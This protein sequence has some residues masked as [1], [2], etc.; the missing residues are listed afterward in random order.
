MVELLFL[1]SVYSP[2]PDCH[3][4]HYNAETLEIDW[5]GMLRQAGVPVVVVLLVGA[6][7]IYRRQRRD[8]DLA[9]LPTYYLAFEVVMKRRGE[10][11]E[12]GETF[13]QFHQ[14]LLTS[15]ATPELEPLRE[16][17]V[18]VDR[19]IELEMYSGK[20]L[21]AEEASL[22]RAQIARVRRQ[23]GKRDDRAA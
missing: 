16:L 10:R 11:R 13:A 6:F 8:V 14:R 17:I 1:P 12:P 5:R 3:G 19:A 20:P 18:A 23:F 21:A 9:L 15:L 4:T 22:L 2:C 7:W